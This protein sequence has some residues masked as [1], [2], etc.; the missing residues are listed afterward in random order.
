MRLALITVPYTS[1]GLDEGE[2]RAPAVLR[3]AGLLDALRRPGNDLADY[4]DVA[5]EPSTPARDPV[6]GIIAPRTL[7][8]MVLA[9]RTAVSRAVDEARLPVV[10]GGECPLLLGCLAAVRDARQRTGLLFVDGHEDAW[11]P[12]ASTTGE[13]ADMELGLALGNSRLN[14][15]DDLAALLPLVRPEDVV[16]LGPRDRGEIEEGGAHSLVG[17]VPLFA[18]EAIQRQDPGELGKSWAGQLRASAGNWW[19]HLDLDVLS[20]DALAAVRYPQPGGLGWDELD[21][22]ATAAL[23]VPGLAGIDLTIY[24][25]DLDPTGHGAEHIVSFAA[26][27]AQTLAYAER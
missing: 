14:G 11:P 23:G 15:M 26:S 22:L 13:A 2:A 16:V 25:P 19:M 17:T 6:S 1:S 10:V 5:F 8:G 9:V 18:A 12:H 3:A 4:G 24:S 21:Q 7:T 27:L 20:S